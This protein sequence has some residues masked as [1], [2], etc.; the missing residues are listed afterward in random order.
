MRL[1]MQLGGS[2]WWSGITSVTL[3]PHTSLDHVDFGI[4][5]NGLPLFATQKI[6]S[7]RGNR[8]S[9][10]TWVEPSSP[11]Y[12]IES[13]LMNTEIRNNTEFTGVLDVM[14]HTSTCSTI[15]SG[16]RYVYLRQPN[17]C[18]FTK[19]P[20]LPIVWLIQLRIQL[21]T[22]ELLSGKS[23]RRYQLVAHG[24]HGM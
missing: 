6:L 8:R 24:V 18:C 16:F 5:A 7:Q 10:A 9:F 23:R 21:R 1:W 14:T 19:V 15:A 4:P 20:F 3:A 13:A 2:Q 17:E 22:V 11:D 12:D